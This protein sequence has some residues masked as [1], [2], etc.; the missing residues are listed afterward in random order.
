MILLISR[1]HLECKQPGEGVLLEF[2]SP[3]LNVLF[4]E[5]LSNRR[6]YEREIEM[7]T[8]LKIHINNIILPLPRNFDKTS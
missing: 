2:F 6:E 7:L 3:S 1:K 8:T 5:L 4:I